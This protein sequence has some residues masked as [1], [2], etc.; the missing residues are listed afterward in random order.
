VLESTA[1]GVGGYF[2]DEW[3]KAVDG[4]S[5]FTPMFFPWWM[6]DDYQIRDHHLRY[7]DLDE[8]ERQL[9]E[10][11]GPAG[12]KNPYPEGGLTMAKLAWRRRKMSAYNNLD[13]FKA[14]YPMDPEEAFVA[15]G[16]NVFDIAKLHKCYVPMDG[17]QGFLWNVDGRLEYLES[18]KGH[19]WMFV[20]PDPRKKRRYVVA[21][22]PTWTISGDPACIQVLDRASMEQVCVWHGSADPE[23]VGEISWAL[24]TFYGPECILNTEVQGGGKRVLEVWREKEYPYIW[25]DRRPDRPKKL[26][27]SMCW[28]S[29]YETKN[30]LVGTMQGVVKRLG[31]I[32][33]HRATYYEC[34]RFVVKEDDTYGPARRSGHD[35]TVIAL[36]IGIVTVQTEHGSMD[37]TA[38]AAPRQYRGPGEKVQVRGIGEPIDIPGVNHS[39]TDALWGDDA[40]IGVDSVY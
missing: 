18:S 4:A 9:L 20:E 8:E 26:T 28:N 16:V 15:T 25:M 29:T 32:I 14:N 2:H 33:H 24:A 17:K 6:H 11:Y 19:T 36:G 1:N 22:D 40:M 12:A 21:V 5:P 39:S 37:W 34:S 27:Q 7:Q 13:D 31:V 23:T 38:L 10:L 30:Y 35:D 3:V